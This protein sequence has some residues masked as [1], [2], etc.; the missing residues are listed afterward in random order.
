MIEKL[1]LTL[2]ADQKVK[3]E[4]MNQYEKLVIRF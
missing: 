1:L 2:L 4:V 3:M